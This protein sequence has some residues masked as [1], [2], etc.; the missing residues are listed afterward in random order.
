MSCM[1]AFIH[2]FMANM[3]VRACTSVCPCAPGVCAADAAGHIRGHETEGLKFNQAVL[4]LTCALRDPT[5]FTS[6]FLYIVPVYMWK[7]LPQ[8]AETLTGNSP[9]TGP[10][11]RWN[12]LAG[13]SL[14][15]K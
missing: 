10:H 13:T 11:T 7:L 15:D 8:F 5:P 6:P 14:Q 9:F 12:P 4:Y 2:S 3:C 1:Y